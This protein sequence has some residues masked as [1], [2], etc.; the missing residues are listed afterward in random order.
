[1]THPLGAALE[2]ADALDVIEVQS[3]VLVRNFE[4]LRRRADD[5]ELDRA[6]Y[7]LLRALETL[8]PSDINTVAAALGLDPSTAGRQVAVMQK[9]GLVERTTSPTDRRRAIIGATT[10]GRRRVKVTS[11]R[12][13][14]RAA[15]LLADW[16]DA[17]LRTLGEMFARYNQAVAARY[18]AARPAAR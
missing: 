15:D 13:R 3:A 8:G 12:R 18:L 1:M 11:R 2:T 16:D 7:L 9:L 6:G 5:S 14:A 4:L 10:G 17:D